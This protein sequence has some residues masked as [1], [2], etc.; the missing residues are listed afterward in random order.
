MNCVKK[1]LANEQS[2]KNYEQFIAHNIITENLSMTPGMK[3]VW[4]WKKLFSNESDVFKSEWH[5][6]NSCA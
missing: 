2:N 1:L 6:S 5:I 4:K 3:H